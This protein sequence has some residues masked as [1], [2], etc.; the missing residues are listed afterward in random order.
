VHWS[1]KVWKHYDQDR[2][3]YLLERTPQLQGLLK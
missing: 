3:Q 2:Q 1:Q